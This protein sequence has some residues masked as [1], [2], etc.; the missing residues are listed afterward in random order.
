MQYNKVS[1]LNFH[2]TTED[3]QRVRKVFRLWKRSFNSKLFNDKFLFDKCISWQKFIDLDWQD[4]DVTEYSQDLVCR[5]WIQL[6]IENATEETSLLLSKYLYPIDRLFILKMKPISKELQINKM[7][8][9]FKQETYFWY[10]HSIHPD[11]IEY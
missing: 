10:T 11:P 3:L 5:S 7:N 6:V 8:D 1:N 4:W 2:L 9:V